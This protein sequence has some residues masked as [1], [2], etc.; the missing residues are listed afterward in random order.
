MLKDLI[1]EEE[2]GIINHM[3]LWTNTEDYISPSDPRFMPCDKWLTDWEWSKDY[4][5]LS[6]PFQESLILEKEVYLPAGIDE[7][8][9]T[10]MSELVYS[11]AALTLKER[12]SHLIYDKRDFLTF[13]DYLTQ[14][15][16]VNL[17]FNTITWIDNKYTAETTSILLPSGKEYKVQNGC[18]VM[19]AL[20]ALAKAFDVAEAF[21]P[22]RLKQSQLMNEH[23]DRTVTL[24][25]SIH[26]LDYLTASYNNN[27]WRSC[28]NFDDG[29]YR[30]GVIEMMNSPYVVVGYL[31]SKSKDTYFNLPSEPA[32]WNSKEW[33]EFF[34]VSK[35]VIS[36]IKGYPY[37]NEKIEAIVLD[38][39]KELYAPV[40]E[41]EYSQN[42][43]HYNYEVMKE[44]IQLP[45]DIDPENSTFYIDFSCGPAMYNDFYG[46]N[47][48]QMYLGKSLKDNRDI[49][50]D[51]S[52]ASICSICGD[53]YGSFDSENDISCSNCLPKIH[54]VC[55]GDSVSEDYVNWLGD[56]AYCDGCFSGLPSCSECGEP[57][58]P[59]NGIGDCFTIA[60]DEDKDKV[61]LAAKT[62][63]WWKNKPAARDYYFCEECANWHRNI[64]GERTDCP[65]PKF[66]LTDIFGHYNNQVIP[67]SELQAKDY[68][69]VE[70]FEPDA[71]S[72]A[73]KTTDSITSVDAKVIPCY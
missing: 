58:D 72:E 52:G 25:L 31:K 28:M 71:V 5:K 19:K 46:S 20:Q 18:K 32:Y 47:D 17:L 61:Y 66:Y 69:F 65:K 29:E 40:F 53:K 8:L 3:R 45:S 62:Y 15:S 60:V 44:D 59:N 6:A 63:D 41:T 12:I 30:R 67:L 1:S 54:C 27:D 4:F 35:D 55:C 48:Y 9:K 49:H 43:Y 13:D 70:D 51:Y 64:E 11:S 42:I 73:I 7:S 21:E 16:C 34:I 2:K 33:R 56:F 10:Q 26:P 37:W 36:G 22:I 39:L 38:W 24:C 14:L 57:V 50:I 23:K 68:E